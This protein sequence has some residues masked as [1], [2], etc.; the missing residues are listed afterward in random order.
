V[1]FAKKEDTMDYD[2]FLELVKN[3]RSI[4]SF[5]A[6]PIPDEYIN[7]IIEAAR[8]APSGF[9]LQPWEF[10]VVKEP[11]LKDSIAQIFSE[12]M[13]VSYKMESARESWQFKPGQTQPP[14]RRRSSSDF[15]KAPVFIILFGDVRTIAGLPMSRRYDHH[16]MQLAFISGLASAFLYMHLAAETLGL[17]S[18]W[19]STVSTPYGACMVKQLLG[20]PNAMEVYDLMAVG[21]PDQGPR[22]KTTRS[23]DEMVHYDYCGEGV[24]RTDEAVRDFIVRIRNP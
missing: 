24:F 22:Y 11:K 5:K 17:A 2:G 13:A 21:Y 8:W 1:T 6:D 10:V 4:R 14:Q 19:V 9:N 16:L 3:R 7:K 20:I 15:N 18:R 12:E 23:L